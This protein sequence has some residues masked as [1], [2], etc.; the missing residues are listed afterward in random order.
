MAVTQDDFQFLTSYSVRLWP[1]FVI[2]FH[3]V[4]VLDDALHLFDHR[5]RDI[6]LLPNH[7]V[8]LVVTVVGISQLAV[9]SDLKLEEF[10]TKL[11]SV[12]NVVSDV[13][14]LLTHGL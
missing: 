4:R 2:L 3:D 12:S 7:G 8:I 11:A 9:W 6:D 5:L 1:Q 10:V 13:K 14:V